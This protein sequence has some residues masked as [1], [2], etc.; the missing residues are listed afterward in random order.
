MNKAFDITEM[1]LSIYKNTNNFIKI[2]SF[3]LTKY[4]FQVKRKAFYLIKI[5]SFLIYTPFIVPSE[6]LLYH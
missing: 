1:L 4:H 5:I 3:S 6:K 2:E